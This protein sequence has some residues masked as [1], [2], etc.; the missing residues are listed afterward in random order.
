MKLCSAAF[1][2]RQ[3]S[4]PPSYQSSLHTRKYT[5]ARNAHAPNKRKAVHDNHL[6]AG[7][8]ARKHGPVSRFPIHT[9]LRV[10]WQKLP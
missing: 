2:S 3:Q 7:R 5:Y 8:D 10:L 1:R 9:H 6:D 4:R